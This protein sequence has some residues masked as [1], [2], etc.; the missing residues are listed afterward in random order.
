MQKG[1]AV[2]PWHLCMAAGETKQNI[3][4]LPTESIGNS[5]LHLETMAHQS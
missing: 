3:R 4:S 1:S 5:Q 2:S